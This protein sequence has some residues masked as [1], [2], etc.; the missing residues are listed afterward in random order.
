MQTISQVW[1]QHRNATTPSPSEA[2][3]K[4]QMPV[5]SLEQA[6]AFLERKGREL[7]GEH[8][9]IYAGDHALLYRLLVYLVGDRQE[10]EKQGLSLRKGILLTGPIGCGKTSLMTILRLFCPAEERY[11]IKSCREVSFEFHR[12]GYEVIG[13]Y[14][15]PVL[16]GGK[17]SGAM[18]F[19]DLGTE[20]PLSHYGNTCNVMGEILLSRYEL[21]SCR[22]IKTHLTT[23]LTSA[24]IEKSYGPRVR[25][26]MREM[27]NLV[28]F[29]S[30]VRDKRR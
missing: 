16:Q 21:F 26:R 7:Y 9:R 4:A 27:F 30:S 8:F 5:W 2:A 11:R 24:E 15:Q 3:V 19:D 6:L 17:F 29:D 10:A 22:G 14:S 20:Q 28:S 23:N 12:E 13:R 18:L 1:Q 25:S